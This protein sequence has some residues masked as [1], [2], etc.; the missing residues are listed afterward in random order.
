MGRSKGYRSNTR[1]K[2][3]M[4]FKRH[5]MIRIGKYLTDYKF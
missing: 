1:D 3:G 5:G 2:F 4:K